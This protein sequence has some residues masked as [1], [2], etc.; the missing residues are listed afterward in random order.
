[1]ILDEVKNQNF[2]HNHYLLTRHL[3]H[4]GYKLVRE[5]REHSIWEN[6]ANKRR[7]SVPRQEIQS[8]K[9][10]SVESSKSYCHS[11]LGIDSKACRTESSHNLRIF[12]K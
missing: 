5:G 4:H 9:I 8:I 6:P 12:A 2:R 1:M 10:S 3:S 11:I 7:T